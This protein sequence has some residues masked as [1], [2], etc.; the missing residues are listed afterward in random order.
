MQIATTI[1]GALCPKNVPGSIPN[2]HLIQESREELF[3]EQQESL[4]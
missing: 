4:Q 2:Y 3:V 1:L